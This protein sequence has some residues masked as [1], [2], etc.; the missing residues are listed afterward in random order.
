MFVDLVNK[1]LEPHDVT[2]IDVRNDANWFMKYK[3]T[4]QQQNKFIDWAIYYL[5]DKTEMSTKRAEGEVSWFILR[6]GLMLKNKKHN[7]V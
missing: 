3:T 2:Y 4:I 6:Y 7:L 1:Q 5:I